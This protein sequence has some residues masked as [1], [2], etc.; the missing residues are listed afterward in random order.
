MNS[1]WIKN[2]LKTDKKLIE[3]WFLIENWFLV[4]NSF[5]II[6]IKRRDPLILPIFTR[7]FFDDNQHHFVFLLLFFFYWKIQMFIR[8]HKTVN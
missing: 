2:Q 5:Q 1:L 7:E 3:Y 6:S 4:Q 8:S